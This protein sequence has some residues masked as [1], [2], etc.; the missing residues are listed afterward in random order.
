MKLILFL[1]LL[2]AMTVAYGQQNMGIGGKPDNSAMLDVSSTSKGLLMPR[3]TTSQRRAINSPASGL[4]VYDTDKG[5][6]MF[7]DGA[8]WKALAFTDESKSEPQ[9]R[10]AAEPNANENMGNRVAISGNY[11]IIGAEFYTASGLTG[12]G[13]AYIFNKTATGWKQVAKLVANDSAARDYFG[14]SVAISGDYAVVGAPN[15]QIGSN[16]AQGKMYVY[17]RTGSDWLL[18]TTFTKPATAAYDDYGWSVAVCAYNTGG[19]AI[20]VGS[21]YAGSSDLGDVTFYRKSGATWSYVQTLAPT[22]LGTSDYYGSTIVMDTDYVAVAATSQDNA[23]YSYANAG[24]VYIYAFGGGVWN[25]QQ[26]IQGATNSGQFGFSMSLYSSMLAVSAPW[27][28]TYSNT[29]ASVY[30]YTRSGTTWSLITSQFL[31]NFEVVPGASSFTP[32]LSVANTTFGISVSLYGN[33]LLVGAAGGTL[34]PNGGSSYYSE[35]VGAVYVYKILP[36]GYLNKYNYITS[37]L[38]QIGNFFGA[39]V[40]VSQD[41]YVIASPK[42]T[43]N[44]QV[45]AGRVYFGNP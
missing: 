20:G 16:V 12:M 29:S 17:H 24:A 7:Y 40:A 25:F 22:D 44:E 28:N 32:T 10:G 9:T 6:L 41:N 33:T 38:P 2:L 43:V 4:L 1:L 31:Y 37:D 18:N 30:I 39:S 21:P 13:A 27:A 34:Y 5:S 45:S 36:S 42:E 11:A 19:P 3:M 35:R 15:K 23:T 26:K 8:A 14:G